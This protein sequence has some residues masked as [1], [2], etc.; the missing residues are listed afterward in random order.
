MLARF[1]PVWQGLREVVGRDR[2]GGMGRLWDVLVQ[3]EGYPLSFQ[4]LEQRVLP[5][6]VAG[7]RPDMLDQLGAAG[8]IVWVGRGSLGP[9]DGKVALVRRERAAWLVDEAALVE[10]RAPM[11]RAIL[12]HMQERGASF[13]VELHR[14]VAAELPGAS[15][16]E[17]LSATWVLVWDGLL[18]NDTFAPL[19]DLHR[20][21]RKSSARS[22]LGRGGGWSSRGR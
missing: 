10:E 3:L 6:R 19:R 1:L 20:S 2:G 5:A 14:A 12:A 16:E 9:K 8:E 11:H 15:L 13:T 17:V 18:T 4:E 21:P 22:S 7:F